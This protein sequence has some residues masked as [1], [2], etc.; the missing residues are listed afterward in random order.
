MPGLGRLMDNKAR[1]DFGP[2]LAGPASEGLRQ[3]II[4][5][6]HEVLQGPLLVDT[7]FDAAK[8][9]ACACYDDFYSWYLL[10]DVHRV[11]CTDEVRSVLALTL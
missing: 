4:G 5:A 7:V 1:I 3:A 2:A 8:N 10:L 11:A 9:P 6:L